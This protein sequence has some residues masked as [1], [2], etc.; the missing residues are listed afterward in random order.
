MFN[1][2]SNRNA[3]RWVKHGALLSAALV[4]IAPL[5]PALA[6]R[7]AP[8]AIAPADFATELRR[9]VGEDLAG[10]YAARSYR[11]IWLTASG[12]L[13][14]AARTLV[15]LADTAWIDEVDPATFPRAELAEALTRLDSDTSPAA[16]ARAEAALSRTFVDLVLAMRK[17]PAAGMTYEHDL[18][19]P[20]LPRRADALW[21]AANAPS[22]V[23][24]VSAM[25]WMHPLYGQLR[26]AAL[27]QASDPDQLD[28]AVRTN[29]E[30]LRALPAPGK[31]RTILVDAANAR[32]WMYE[33]DR[34]VDSM[35]VVVGKPELQTPMYA[36]YVRYA[37][38]NPYW[39]VPEDLVAGKI[40]AN[41][42]SRGPSYL[43][44]AGYQV[45]SDWSSE[46]TPVDPAKI[47][48]RQVAS[49]AEN[50]RVRQLPGAAN[51]MGVVKFEFPNKYGIY[52]HDT[53][54]KQ[55]MLKDQRQF[56]SGCVR[57]EDAPRLG[58]WLFQGP[59]PAV[60]SEPEQK[61]DLPAIV[62]VY[63]TYL[64]ARVEAGR[65]ALGPDPYGR[66][67]F[68]GPALASI[69]GTS[70]SAARK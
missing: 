28:P 43:R 18:L 37:I 61:V 50:V 14:P 47:D 33:G 23:D 13:D 45:L 1:R 42:V 2:L 27:A 17:A 60:S 15:A 70:T 48:W 69:S 46:A 39:N 22:L 66:D 29:L 8:V 25:Q 49:G 7:A 24:Y 34:P 11:P 58:R 44:T 19:R 63:I 65:I 32:L 4:A 35:K 56:S 36:G 51:A 10:V 53:P 52:L 12:T 5:Q 3:A 54:D 26:Q 30:R 55:L 9:G 40:A 59:M 21:A 20:Q 67:G 41:A 16:R 57:L 38:L 62:P 6:K 68:Q 64:T 31:G